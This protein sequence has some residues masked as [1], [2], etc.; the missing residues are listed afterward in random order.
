VN[1]FSSMFPF[2]I[3]K[4]GIPFFFLYL[5]ARDKLSFFP[6]QIALGSIR[7]LAPLVNSFYDS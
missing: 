4:S 1:D 5:V 6:L 3:A 2:T 7:L